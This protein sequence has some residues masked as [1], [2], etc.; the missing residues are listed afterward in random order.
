[1][2]AKQNL[3]L[4]QALLDTLPRKH[5]DQWNDID[6]KCVKAF[7]AFEKTLSNTDKIYLRENLKGKLPRSFYYDYQTQKW[8]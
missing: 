7:D 5:I 1:M 2:T 8:L 3:N 6:K 4:A